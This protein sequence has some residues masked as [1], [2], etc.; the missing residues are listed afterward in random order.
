MLS[1]WIHDRLALGL[2]QAAL[3]ARRGRSWW[4]ARRRETSMTDEVLHAGGWI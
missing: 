2:A 4:A 3:K 1:N